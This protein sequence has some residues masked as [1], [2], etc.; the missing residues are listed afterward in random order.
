MTS[1]EG[2]SNPRNESD[3]E[4][5]VEVNVTSEKEVKNLFV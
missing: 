4:G 5:Q 1:V 2:T 3:I